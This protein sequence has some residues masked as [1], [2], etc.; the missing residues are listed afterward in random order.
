MYKNYRIFPLGL[1][2]MLIT[3]CASNYKL[4]K[5][6]SLEFHNQTTTDGIDFSYHYD[7][8]NETHNKKYAKHEIKNQVRL[9]AVKITN[10]TGHDINP[11]SDAL[12]V[13]NKMTVYPLDQKLAR[14]QMKQGVPIYLL[15]L[16]FSPITLNTNSANADGTTNSNSF[17]A[18]LIIGPGLTAANM[19]VAGSANKQFTDELDTYSLYK[20]LKNGQTMYGLVAFKDISADEITLKLK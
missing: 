5:P 13:I 12:F 17:P 7:V 11:M 6:E 4:I 15:Y 19:I 9:V 20:Q 2:I 10:H 16:L 3:S 8:L 14:D 18:G 1:S